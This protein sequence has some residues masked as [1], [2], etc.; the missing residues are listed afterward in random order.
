MHEENSTSE[1]IGLLEKIQMRNKLVLAQLE[2]KN[3]MKQRKTVRKLH[4]LEHS[5][6]A[7]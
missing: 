7:L 6:G 3:H 5:N 2:Y 1:E 4:V